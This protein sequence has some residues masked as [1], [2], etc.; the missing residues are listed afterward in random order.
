MDKKECLILACMRKDAKQPLINISKKVN[1]P[2][3]TVYEK[4]R[5]SERKEII[6][7]YTVLLDFQKLGYSIRINMLIKAKDRNALGKLLDEKKNV[8]SVFKINNG[9]D[10]LIDCIFQNM[11]ELQEFEDEIEEHI[12]KKQTYYVTDELKREE[13]FS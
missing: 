13:F 3:S 7:K 11:L 10:F 1:I 12:T 2:M 5:K 4:V 9:Y 6:K 8:N